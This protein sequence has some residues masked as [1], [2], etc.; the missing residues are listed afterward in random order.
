M[1][2]T[3]GNKL[4][5]KIASNSMFVLTGGDQRAW[6]AWWPSQRPRLVQAAMHAFDFGVVL[7]KYC[8]KRLDKFWHCCLPR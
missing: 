2:S 8:W 3:S 4:E 6:R 7:L 5:C 1:I